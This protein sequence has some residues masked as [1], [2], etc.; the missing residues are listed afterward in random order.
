[1]D[2]QSLVEELGVIAAAEVPRPLVLACFVLVAVLFQRV[3]G[4]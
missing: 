2:Y 1:M 4:E 3:P